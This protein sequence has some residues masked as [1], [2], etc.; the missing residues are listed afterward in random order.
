MVASRAMKENTGIVVRG[1]DGDCPVVVRRGAL[2]SLGDILAP[3]VRGRVAAVVTDSNVGPLYAARAAAALEAAGFR[4]AV[5]E[6]PAGE[7]SKDLANLAAL[8]DFLHGAGVTRQDLVVALGGGVVGDLAGFA[9]ATWLRGVAVAQVPASLL[10]FVDSSIG[11]KTAVDLPA[12]KNLAGAFH[13]PVAVVEDPQ[14]LRSLP[15]REFA[16]GMAE[17]AKYGCIRDAAFFAWLEA[18]AGAPFSDG[19]AERIIAT[20]AAHKAA[21]VSADER[22]GGLRATLNFG[23]TVGHAVEKV[24][25]Y[26]AVPHGEAVAI[27]MVAAAKIGEALG[28]T[29]PGTAARTA[30]LLA[31]L[32]LPTRLAQRAEG[33]AP[34]ALLDAMM[35][36]KKKFGAEIRFVLLDRI[37]ACSVVPLAPAEIAALLPGAL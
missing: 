18:R 14:L 25:G 30:E 20:C 21:V 22:E 3:L 27:G 12:G 6:I 11:G 37:G 8:W 35:S 13:Q 29:E 7:A 17:V 32:A 15:P 2:D 10:A 36:D 16:Q 23:H 9:A 24:L 19:D 4:A 31:R 5:R 34:A 26:G 1:R 33:V 28:R